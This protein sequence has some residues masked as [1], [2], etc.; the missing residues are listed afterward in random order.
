MF[1][2]IPAVGNVALVSSMVGA[3][4]DHLQSQDK[5]LRFRFRFRFRIKFRFGHQLLIFKLIL[6]STSTQETLLVIV[7]LVI[8]LAATRKTPE[9]PHRFEVPSATSS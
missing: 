4:A 8:P 5:R 7:I 9:S 2:Y 1:T 6:K 3:L